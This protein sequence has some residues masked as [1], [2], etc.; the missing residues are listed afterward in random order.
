VLLFVGSLLAFVNLEIAYIATAG[1]IGFLNN[2]TIVLVMENFTNDKDILTIYLLCGW[3]FSEITLGLLFYAKLLDDYFF[4]LMGVL[5]FIYF[6]SVLLYIKKNN[7]NQAEQLSS[8]LLQNSHD[9]L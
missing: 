2:I 3:A 1:C 7:G 8:T 6:C 4:E 9:S 5:T